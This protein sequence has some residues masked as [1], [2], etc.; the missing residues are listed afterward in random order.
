M[1]IMVIADSLGSHT[2][3]CCLGWQQSYLGGKALAKALEAIAVVVL[4]AQTQ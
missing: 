2:S 1:I 4:E 3:I